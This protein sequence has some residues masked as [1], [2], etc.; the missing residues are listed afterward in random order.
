MSLI[1]VFTTLPTRDEALSL[2]GSLVERGLVACAQIDTIESLYL[3]QGE[4]RQ[5]QEWRL[6]L[7]APQAHYEAIEAAILALHPYDLP[8]IHAL[9]LDRVHAPYGDW[10]DAVGLA[11]GSTPG[12]TQH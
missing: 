7:K 4:L 6:T 9:Q 1:A 11:T 8:A 12:R 2:A 3:W 10:I 5:E